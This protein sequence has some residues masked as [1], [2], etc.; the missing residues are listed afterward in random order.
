MATG[1]YDDQGIWIFGEDDPAAPFSDTL[2]LGMESV[3]DEIANDR[4]RLDALEAASGIGTYT[5]TLGNAALGNGVLTCRWSRA[6]LLVFWSIQMTLGSTSAVSGGISFTPPVTPAA[7]TLVVG[8]GYVGRGTSTTGR[9][10]TMFRQTTG[11]VWQ[12][13]YTGGNVSAVSPLSGGTWQAAD[14]IAGSGIYLAA[15]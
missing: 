7:N 4:V 3:S 14:V 8:H 6:G 9:V 2:N 1:A 15:A 12:I 10:T 5:P 11:P 13:W